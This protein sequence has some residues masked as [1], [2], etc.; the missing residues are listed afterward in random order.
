MFDL[1]NVDFGLDNLQPDESYEGDNNWCANG[2][3]AP[4]AHLS[5]VCTDCQEEEE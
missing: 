4:A 5:D 1:S 3:E 2:C